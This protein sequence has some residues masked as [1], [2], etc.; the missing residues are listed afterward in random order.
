MI[1]FGSFLPSLLGWLSTTNSTRAWEPTLLWNHYTNNPSVQ[2]NASCFVRYDHSP[3]GFR[4][5]RLCWW[6]G[7][8]A[9]IALAI[10]RQIGLVTWLDSAT[11]YPHRKIVPAVRLPS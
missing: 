11:L 7:R 6:N 9:G 4:L 1:M 2:R 8:I 5:K 10:K 3:G